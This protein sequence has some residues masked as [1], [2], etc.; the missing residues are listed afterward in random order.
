MGIVAVRG[1][2]MGKPDA[3]ERHFKQRDREN[4]HVRE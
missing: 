1:P 4:E 2:R 3:E